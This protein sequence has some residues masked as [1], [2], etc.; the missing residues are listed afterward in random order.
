M[1]FFKNLFFGSILI[2]LISISAQAQLT[3]HTIS[4]K[5]LMLV[6]DSR[7]RTIPI[8]IYESKSFLYKAQHQL[9]KMPVVIINH[10]Y[11]V[12]NTE[13]SFIA[14]DL[15]RKG[16]FVV[17]IQHD[18]KSDKP[19]P[20]QGNIFLTRKPLW[21][22]GEKNIQF[23][24]NWLKQKYSYLDFANLI[25]IGHSN[26]GDITMLFITDNPQE[27]SKAISLDN[28][29][30][31]IP[32]TLHPQI[33]SLR[34][35]DQPA[36]PGVLPTAAEQQKFNIRIIQLKDAKHIDMSDEG[37]AKVHQ[38]ILKEISNFLTQNN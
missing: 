8:E 38:E 7:Q 37:P 24:L 27:V 6:D 19:L 23:I 21:E 2:A 29:R 25:M 22:R 34:S 36:D 16:Y 30:M 10:G 12:K 32:K 31:P 33:L 18:L 15:A 20:N 14:N 5:S 9:I 3:D 13:Y 17:S 35:I 26:G 1:K 4:S 28:C 11:G